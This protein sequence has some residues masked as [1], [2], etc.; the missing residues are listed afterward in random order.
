MIEPL[1]PK[2]TLKG[3]ELQDGDIVCFQRTVT[4]PVDAAKL[5]GNAPR[6]PYG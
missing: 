3:A 2:L 4:A 1:K 5:M 6:E